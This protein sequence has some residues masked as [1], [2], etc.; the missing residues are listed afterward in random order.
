MK[1]V[2]LVHNPTA[3]KEDHSGEALKGQIEAAGYACRYNSTKE[4][5]WKKEMEEDADLIA[6]A[7]GDGTVRKVVKRL[8]KKM[9]PARF[10]SLGLLPM[11]TAN[12][13]ANA[14]FAPA[15]CGQ[16]DTERLIRS[17][18]QGR[19]KRIDIGK[20]ENVPGV[21]F[22]LE[23]FGFGIFPYLMKEMKKKE[24]QYQTPEDELNGALKT[25]HR[26]LLSYEPRHCQLEIDGTDHSGRFYM[27][28]VM[29][30]R[31]IGPNM[32]LA[33]LASPDDGELEVV[34]V[35]EAHM[36]K[37]SNFLLQNLTKDEEP[38]QFHTLKGK[39]IRIKWDGTRMHADDKMLKLE[40]ER[41]I[42]FEIKQGVLPFFIP[43]NESANG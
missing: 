16:Q 1:Q 25:L 30:I 33:P 2:N 10:P 6:I 3:G 40:R 14:L 12:N 31:S 38:Y 11:G 22:F 41:A 8:F 13:F 36:E 34:L 32:V 17:W 35:P 23:G 37:F 18:Q 29:N 43:Q 39:N 26:I 9:D 27:V 20:V 28:E 24:G 4:K 21:D 5:G 19:I 7:G 15:K 42:Q